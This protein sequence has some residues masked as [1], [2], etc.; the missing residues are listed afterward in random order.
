M[1]DDYF[2]IET[3][4]AARV[5]MPTDEVSQRLAIYNGD[6]AFQRELAFAWETAGEVILSATLD[7]WARLPTSGTPSGDSVAAMGLLPD[8]IA[9]RITH[10][11]RAKYTRPIDASWIH[12]LTLI[13][14]EIFTT[15]APA[16]LVI[17]GT[18]NYSAAVA[19]AI[20]E[21]FPDSPDQQ[22][23][24]DTVY[25]LGSVETEISIAQ[26]ALLRQHSAVASQTEEGARF[27]QTVVEILQ[28]AVS[29]AGSLQHRT[30]STA[31]S[32]R[33][34]LGKASEVAAAS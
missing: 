1:S 8:T 18:N 23:I 7:F 27:Q 3:P 21:A 2:L 5:P 22:R 13:G 6:G 34:M 30:A 14:R 4:A 20:R 10:H 25:R 29:S 19:K 32:A 24:I 28:G 16:P 9:S 33:G 31:G 17:E 26:L 11:T 15:G 12:L